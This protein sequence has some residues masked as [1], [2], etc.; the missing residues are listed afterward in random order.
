MTTQQLSRTLAR[1]LAVD[2]PS[3][4]SGDAALDVLAAANEGL[5]VF[6]Q[7]APAILKRTTF[8]ATFKAPAAVSLQFSA[9]YGTT[10]TGTPF[11]SSWF[12]CGVRVDGVNPD[13]EITGVDSVL[14][15]WLLATLTASA[16]VHFD[17]QTIAATIERITSDIRIYDGN[18]ARPSVLVRDTTG[19]IDRRRDLHLTDPGFPKYYRLEPIAI[20]AGGATVGLLRIYP[21]PSVDMVV[22]FEAEVA[23]ASLTFADMVRGATVPVAD[24]WASM[25]TPLCEAALSY[26][27]LWRDPRTR[28]DARDRAERT[29]SLRIRKMAQDL[30]CPD[31]TVGTP[32]GF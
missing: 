3:N 12:G 30:V 18:L 7:E 24:A 6:Y 22:R 31:N 5:A 21:A 25:L 16:T 20:A 10:L 26:S 32:A 4:L 8:S 2:D 19:L 28:Q 9:Q 29:I 11:D 13:N 17:C 14:D 1:N 15:E 23:N 27:P